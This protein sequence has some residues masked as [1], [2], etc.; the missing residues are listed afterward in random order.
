MADTLTP[1]HK[2]LVIESLAVLANNLQRERDAWKRE[3]ETQHDVAVA[4]F[5]DVRRLTGALG[6]HVEL[7]QRLRARLQ[8]AAQV[9]A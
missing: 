6:R 1:D 3:A 4:A 2:D 7:N 5:E 8:L 9:A